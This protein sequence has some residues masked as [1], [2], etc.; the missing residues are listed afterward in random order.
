M[1]N[2]KQTLHD[3]KKWELLLAFKD[4]YIKN[5]MRFTDVILSDV[6][7][8]THIRREIS[9]IFSSYLVIKQS[10]SFVIWFAV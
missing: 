1:G 5:D 2:E 10:S 8:I 7:Y 3:N 4:Q 9:W 6:L